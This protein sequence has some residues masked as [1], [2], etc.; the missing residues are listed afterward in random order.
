MYLNKNQMFHEYNMKLNAWNAFIVC[1]NI[2]EEFSLCV[3]D[4][5]YFVPNTKRYYSMI[6]LSTV[7]FELTTKVTI[8]IMT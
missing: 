4:W 1:A 3:L 8:K 7:C 2:Y 5:K 6:I